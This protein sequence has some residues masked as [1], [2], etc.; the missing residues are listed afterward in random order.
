MVKAMPLP[1]L[2]FTNDDAICSAYV[3]DLDKLLYRYE[4]DPEKPTPPQAKYA[5]SL[6]IEEDL[7]ETKSTIS[8]KIDAAKNGTILDMSMVPRHTY[9]KDAMTF[10]DGAIV[11]KLCADHG[12]KLSE[13]AL[14]AV[15]VHHGG[16]SALAN[17][18]GSRMQ[19]KDLGVLIHAA[20]LMS[21]SVQ[22]GEVLTTHN[23]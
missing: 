22:R 17:D 5:A 6:G 19:M 4:L 15:C 9:R 16:F 11:M 14:H 23:L 3:H 1:P 8:A 21:A 20:D 12:L 10:D 13:I 7:L 18:R 2:T